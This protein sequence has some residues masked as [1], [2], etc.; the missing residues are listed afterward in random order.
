M[1]PCF[2]VENRANGWATDTEFIGDP[3]CGQAILPQPESASDEVFVQLGLRILGAAQ[4]RRRGSP[5]LADHVRQIVLLG[6]DEEVIGIDAGRVV[7]T[8]ADD[9]LRVQLHRVENLEGQPVCLC[10][11]FATPPPTNHAITIFVLGACPSPAA[12]VAEMDVP[13][14]THA[15]WCF[16]SI[17]HCA[18]P[19]GRISTLRLPVRT[20]RAGSKPWRIDSGQAT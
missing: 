2:L 16:G 14:E 9:L 12:R 13:G 1:P 10:V 11:P 20:V 5:F 7:T 18:P 19:C 8:V 6:A 4:E 3:V 17:P 15:D